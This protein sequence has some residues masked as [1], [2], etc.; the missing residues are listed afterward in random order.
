MTEWTENVMAIPQ[1]DAWTKVV[2]R[3][4]DPRQSL[5]QCRSE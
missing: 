3:L 5:E 4:A 2:D 1:L